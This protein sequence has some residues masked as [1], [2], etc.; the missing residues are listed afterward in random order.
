[1][2]IME[3][4]GPI[5]IS[6]LAGLS[7]VIGGL[8][9]YFKV[10]KINEF[11][12]FC[13][14]LSLSVM[15]GVSIIELMP[16]SSLIVAEEYGFITGFILVIIT[17]FLGS[18]SINTINRVIKKYNSKKTS[19]NLYRVGLL[20][21]FALMLHNFPEG[22]ATFM[23]SYKDI[24]LGIQLSL[25]IMMHNIPEGISISVPIYYSTGNKSRGV[26][27]SF[28]SGLAE[29]LGAVL[30]YLLFKNYITDISISFVLIFVAGIMI[31][32][33]I[34][35]LYPEAMKY[36][37]LKQLY[38]GMILGIIIVLFNHFIF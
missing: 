25:A 29:P 35:E 22:I 30:T 2:I 11:I 7:T 37:K 26:K 20:S 16:S 36:N 5:L 32:L 13:L 6:T 1:M 31:T 12:V 23:T 19:N 17:F 21:M 27:Y 24:Y 15:I 9:V 34:N 28:I 3:I 14:S 8:I 18:I 10:K 38:I 4:F 33:S